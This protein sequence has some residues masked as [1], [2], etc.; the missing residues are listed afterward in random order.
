MNEDEKQPVDISKQP[1]VFGVVSVF[2]LYAS[3]FNSDVL[4]T[5]IFFYLFFLSI[6]EDKKGEIYSVCCFNFKFLQNSLWLFKE[7]LVGFSML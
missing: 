7:S 1:I 5:I 6:C 2:L 3:V 4:R